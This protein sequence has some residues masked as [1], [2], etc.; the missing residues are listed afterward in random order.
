VPPHARQHPRSHL[1]LL[2][3]SGPIQSVRPRTRVSRDLGVADIPHGVVAA[4]RRLQTVAIGD[5]P[6]MP[7]SPTTDRQPEMKLQSHCPSL[8]CEV[9]ARVLIDGSEGLRKVQRCSGP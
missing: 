6:Y 2:L 4:V 7:A 8:G 1:R 9:V 3:G 5:I